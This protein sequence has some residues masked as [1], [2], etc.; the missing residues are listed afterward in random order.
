MNNAKINLSQIMPFSGM[1]LEKR[2][3]GGSPLL[4]PKIMIYLP[5]YLR[6]LSIQD[7]LVQY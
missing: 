4:L 2:E 6:V 3:K 7:K 1:E 5:F